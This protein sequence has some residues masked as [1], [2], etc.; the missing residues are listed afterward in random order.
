MN[1]DNKIAFTEKKEKNCVW[2]VSL[3]STSRRDI[4]DRSWR[5]DNSF[6]QLAKTFGFESI[7]TCVISD[8][9]SDLEETNFSDHK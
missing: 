6:D 9:E 8:S 3:F 4:S 7:N 5:R 2:K 1:S